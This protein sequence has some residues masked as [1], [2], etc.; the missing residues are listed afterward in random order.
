MKIR[1]VLEEFQPYI[2]EPSNEEIAKKVGISVSSVIRFDTNTSPFTPK[3]W[4]EELSRI[5]VKLPV[6]QYP[7]TKYTRI[8]KALADYCGVNMNNITMTNGGDEAID[9][10]IKTF[11]DYEDKVIISVPTYSMFNIA[12]QICGGKVIKVDRKKEPPF[13]DN[14]D[15]IIKIGMNEK[16]SAIFLC[17]PNNPTGNSIEINEIKRIAEELSCAVIIDEAYY[18]FCGK[19]AINL[20]KDYSNIIIIRTLSKAF[21]LAGARI[22][23]IIANEDTI[24]KLNLVRPPNSLSIISL[25]LGEIALSDIKQI[26]EW[27]KEII[28]ERERCFNILKEIN[29]I[30]PYPSDANFILFK[31]LKKNANIVYEDLMR[32]GLVVR[33]LSNTK[34]LENCLRFNINT[35]ENNDLFLGELRRV[36][37]D[38]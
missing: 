17:N 19:T 24:N 22:G 16:V 20:I 27:V 13:A 18:E 21:S 29:G 28:S 25:T 15:E 36:L 11:I 2:W 30:K 12:V 10:I 4:L 38:G 23:Y 5:L 34:G 14:I 7:D 6:N 1:K 3:K 8:R 32:K 31:V 33:N 37:E 26:K 9:I 35:K